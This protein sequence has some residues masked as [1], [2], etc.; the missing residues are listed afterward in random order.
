MTRYNVTVTLLLITVV[1]KCYS[2]CK[3]EFQKEEKQMG[4]WSLFLL[5]QTGDETMDFSINGAEAI[6]YP[7]KKIVSYYI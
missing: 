6:D 3:E 4:L 7:Y 5:L 2:N 1:F